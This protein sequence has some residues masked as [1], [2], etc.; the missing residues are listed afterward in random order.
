MASDRFVKL[1]EADI[2]S[3]SEEQENVNTKKKTLYESNLF[4]EFLT[5]EDEGRELQQIPAAELQQLAIKL[6]VLGVRKKNG[7]EYEPSSLRRF[8]RVSTGSFGKTD[9]RFPF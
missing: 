2:K 4:K 6:I 7:E 1:T 3:F 5:S 9:A 8:C